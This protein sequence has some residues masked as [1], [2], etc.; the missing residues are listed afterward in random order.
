VKTEKAVAISSAQP[1]LRALFFVL[2]GM[3]LLP[4]ASYWFFYHVT[5]YVPD[6]ELLG[7]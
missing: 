1:E 5:I 2:A 7:L 4:V 3:S 6:V